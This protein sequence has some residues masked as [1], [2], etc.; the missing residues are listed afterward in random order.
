MTKRGKN[1]KG[2]LSYDKGKH[3]DQEIHQ[4]H[5]DFS[6]PYYLTF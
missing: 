1:K 2:W 6:I 4:C 3:L 5:I